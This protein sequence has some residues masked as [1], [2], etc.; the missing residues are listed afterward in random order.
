MPQGDK[1]EEEEE[2]EEEEDNDDD[3]DDDDEETD[4]F[5][6]LLPKGS[7]TVRTTIASELTIEFL[8]FELS[9]TL[10]LKHLVSRIGLPRKCFWISW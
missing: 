6:K 4:F 9:L 3:D 5:Y 2:E 10:I 7:L 1:T 8:A